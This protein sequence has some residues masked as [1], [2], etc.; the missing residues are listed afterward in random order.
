[1]PLTIGGQLAIVASADL[2]GLGVRD[3]SPVQYNWALPIMAPLLVPWLVILGLLATKPNR[4]AAAWLIWLPLGCVMAVTLMLPR[5]P[6]GADVLMDLL[7]AMAFGLA[8]VWLLANYLRGA[9]R[10]LTFF[11]VLTALAGFTAVAYT[12]THSWWLG[13]TEA[14]PIGIVLGLGVL[15]STLALSL[16]GLICRRRFRPLGLYL[17]LFLSL[18]VVWLAIAAPFFV[19]AQ[20]SSG[21]RMSWG[22]FFMPILFVVGGNFALLLPF[23]ILSSASPFFRAR[24]KALLQVEQEAPPALAVPSPETPLKI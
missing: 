2:G 1:M 20:I 11:R 24:L 10:V 22:E 15:A 17:S 6:V 21:W 7:G 5:M 12:S 9:N 18:A 23:L 3:G 4:T 13:D 14:L 16:G 19:F 8:A